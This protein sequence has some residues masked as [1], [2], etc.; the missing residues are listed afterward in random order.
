IDQDDL[1]DADEVLRGLRRGPSSGR[2]G[3]P[4]RV[5]VPRVDGGEQGVEG[6]LVL[7]P[8]ACPPGTPY[9]RP[10]RGHHFVPPPIPPTSAAALTSAATSGSASRSG[11]SPPE[12]RESSTSPSTA[13]A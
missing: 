6:A 5:R 10:D 12:E 11:A 8:R 7:P 9:A 13:I 4:P 3:T 1:V 2:D